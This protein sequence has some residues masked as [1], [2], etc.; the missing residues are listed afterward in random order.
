MLPRFHRV[1]RSLF[2]PP[3]LDP[4]KALAGEWKKAGLKLSGSKIALAVGS[5]GISH[6]PLLVKTLVKILRG[7]GA[8]PFIVPAMG[9]HGGATAQGQVEV[10][11]DLGVTEESAGCPIRSS[12]E[13]VIRGQTAEG[14][15][16]YMDR[17][18]AES[19]GIVL[20]NRVK[21]HTSF[22]GELESGLHKMLAIGL[23]K[24]KAATL[25]HTGGPRSLRDNMP[26]VAK[27]LLKTS[28]F[29]AGIGLVEDALQNIV[30][31]RVLDK[32]N[33]EAGEKEL[34]ALAR[35]LAP[36]LPLSD[37]DV[38]VVDEMGKDISGTG[39]DTHVIGRL[40]IQGEPEPD[41]PHITALAV[42]RLSS[43]THGNALGIGL[44]D[45][46]TEEALQSIDLEKTR[47]NVETTGNLKR[48]IIPEICADSKQAVE[49]AIRFASA[50][51]GKPDAEINVLRIRNT[52]RLEDFFVSENRLEDVR[53]LPDV[54]STK[55]VSELHFIPRE[56][57]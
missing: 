3:P 4:E 7:E 45:F 18:A 39:M 10:L 30:A 21:P 56:W 12:M 13:T 55:L 49:A 14:L 50:K 11:R 27:V 53:N 48:G 22:T 19:D 9:S 28:P 54:D 26:K 1:R 16:A 23:G 37:W 20:L 32:G 25:L 6:L 40:G 42:L 33:L 52:L 35:N 51:T 57:R 46:S 2:S 24:E 34:L 5:R 36:A 44:A 41:S 38:L 17:A 15:D 47:K 31:L 43:A 8:E 29:L